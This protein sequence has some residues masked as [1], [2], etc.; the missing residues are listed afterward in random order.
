MCH[1]KG[2]RRSSGPNPLACTGACHHS[3][4]CELTNKVTIIF[5]HYYFLALF[6]IS[7][8]SSSVLPGMHCVEGSLAIAAM[9]LMSPHSGLPCPSTAAP[10]WWPCCFHHPPIPPLPCWFRSACSFLKASSAHERQEAGP[11]HPCVQ[12]KSQ[13]LH[14]SAW[15]ILYYCGID[16]HF[17]DD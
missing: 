15:E 13:A 17:S 9:P 11:R 12:K 1:L 2:R 4:P 3:F 16:F 14:F 6:K 5:H 10:Q 8:T 7:K